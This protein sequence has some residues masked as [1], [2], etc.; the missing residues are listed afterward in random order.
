[1]Y[2]SG[3]DQMT[4]IC[5]YVLMFMFLCFLPSS[6]TPSELLVYT[7]VIAYNILSIVDEPRELSSDEAKVYIL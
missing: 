5:S 3:L 6:I 2:S 4:C 1:M 7:L